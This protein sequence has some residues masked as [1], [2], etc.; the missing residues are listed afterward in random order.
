MKKIFIF[1]VMFVLLFAQYSY[2][3]WVWSPKTNKWANP[4][5]H[6]FDTPEEQFDWAK[7]YF[8]DGD[9]RK[10]VSEF[11]KLAKKFPKNKLAPEAVYYTALSYEKLKKHYKAYETYESILATYPLTERFDEIAERQYL[12][13]EIFFE[14]KAYE[15]AQKIFGKTLLNAPYSKVSDV[16]QY[17]IGLCNLRTK[18]YSNARDEFEKLTENYTFSPYVDDASFLMGLCS[19]KISSGVKDYDEGLIDKAVEDLEYFLRRFQTS[20]Y[21]SQAESLLKKLKHKKAEHLYEVAHFYEKLNKKFAA[22]KYYEEIIYSYET[23]E[24]AKKA[25]AKL[26]LLETKH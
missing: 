11:R 15:R 25:Q 17:K 14:K 12:I 26:K 10:A 4:T 7:G 8:D 20:E 1:A 16:I 23:T 3:F 5:Y 9:Y 21:V 13:A 24:W 2:A 19:F 18:Q 22:E 6:A